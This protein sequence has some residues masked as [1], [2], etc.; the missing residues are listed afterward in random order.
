[1]SKD[2]RTKIENCVA[3]ITREVGQ[4]PADAYRLANSSFVTKHADALE[5]LNLQAQNEARVEEL[6]EILRLKKLSVSTSNG[7]EAW[8]N[9]RYVATRLAALRSNDSDSDHQAG[10]RHPDL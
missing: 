3:Q 1:M 4:F 10:S 7:Q 2:Y 5:A 9:A 8:I 6:E